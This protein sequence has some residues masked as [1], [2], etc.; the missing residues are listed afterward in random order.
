MLVVNAGVQEGDQRPAAGEVQGGIILKADDAGGVQTLHI[1]G[2]EALGDGPIGI[3]GEVN[4]AKL[5]GRKIE[6][7]VAP[8]HDVVG[9]PIRPQLQKLGLSLVLDNKIGKARLRRLQR[10][11]I[12]A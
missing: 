10:M 8:V 5:G 4:R 3:P 9:Y 7:G 11:Y 1:H 6:D 2:G 12:I